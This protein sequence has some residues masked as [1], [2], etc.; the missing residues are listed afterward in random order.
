M[1]RNFVMFPTTWIRTG[2]LALF[3]PKDVWALKTIL[4]LAIVRGSFER[5]RGRPAEWYPASLTELSAAAHL[6]RNDA[7]VGVRRLV[8]LGLVEQDPNAGRALGVHQRTSGFRFAGPQEPFFPLP[9]FH[10]AQSDFLA[11][12]RRGQAALA[13]LK[14]YLLLGTFRNTKT[15][16][17]WLS[18]GKMEDFSVRRQHIRAALSLLYGAGLVNVYPPSDKAFWQYFVTG[19]AR[20]PP[21]QTALELPEEPRRSGGHV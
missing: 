6:S 7:I 16:M 5:K 8:E 20:T 1:L 13:A 4:G 12:L 9:H 21:M 17:T 11:H 14:I 10:L 19:L 3:A 18:Y 2:G 15:G